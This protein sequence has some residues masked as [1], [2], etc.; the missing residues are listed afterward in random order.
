MHHFRG[1][2]GYYRRL[3]DPKSFYDRTMPE[4]FGGDYESAR[5]AANPL[6]R[7]QYQMLADA[8]HRQVCPLVAP[9]ARVLE[10]GP[11]PGTWTKLL[12]E[13]NPSARYTLVDISHEM[14]SRAQGALADRTNIDFVE[15]DLLAYESSDPYDFFFSSRAIEYM[16][17]KATAARKIASLLAPGA[18]GAVITK[19]PKAFFDRVRGRTSALHV[20]QIAPDDL[21]CL[22]ERAGLIVERVR[23]ATAT[24]PGI[25][26]ATLNN[27]VYRLLKQVPLFFPLSLFAESYLVTFRKPV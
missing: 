25:G 26:S 15:S 27:F 10:T 3:M 4:K 16:P 19:M 2:S 14:L 18:T 21:V 12:L 11:G 22:L 17:D 23:I 6:L 24:F 5:W 8:V 20:G 1:H 13:A 9:A 7:A